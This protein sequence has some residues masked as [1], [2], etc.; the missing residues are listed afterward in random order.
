VQSRGFVPVVQAMAPGT[1]VEYHPNP[2]ELAFGLTPPHGEPAF[3]LAPGFNVVFAGNMGTVQA[4]DTVLKA[5]EF[6][7]PHPEVRLV[8]V[9]S[10]SRS[11]WLVE[12][13]QQR[14]LV[15]VCLP[16]RFESEKMPG[17]FAQASAL[18]VSLTGGTAVSQTVPSKIQAYLAAGRPIVA[19]LDGEGARVVEESG[20]G[21]ASPAED[22]SA[23]A[24]AILSLMAMPEAEL[25][26]MGE[27]GRNYYQQ[28]FEPAML[29][30][31]L[32]QHFEALPRR[33]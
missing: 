27:A 24:Q 21:L 8:L 2:G 9:G 25:K 31:R 22:P 4:L 1:S 28:H 18:L 23:L 12:Q 5:A 6:L 17:I 11:K 15:N 10:G 16:G 7:L 20:A 19:S 13:I 33:V 14:G 29:A 32:I 30:K 26:R 3:R